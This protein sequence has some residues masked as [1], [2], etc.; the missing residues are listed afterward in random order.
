MRSAK[1]DLKIV[2]RLTRL[3]SQNGFDALQR[4]NPTIM[5]PLLD[6]RIQCLERAALFEKIGNLLGFAL[7]HRSA[8]IHKGDRSTLDKTYGELVKVA[9]LLKSKGMLEDSKWVQ[10][11]IRSLMSGDLISLT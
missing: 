10:G 4:D 11:Q 9:N 3:A 2:S 8:A 5:K 1:Q 6:Y 7:E